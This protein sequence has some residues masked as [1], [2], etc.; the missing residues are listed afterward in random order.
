MGGIARAAASGA[1]GVVP[2][3]TASQCRAQ[4]RSSRRMP[5]RFPAQIRQHLAEHGR[6]R[7]GLRERQPHAP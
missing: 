1:L 5:Q 2:T 4:S 6:V 3:V 7:V